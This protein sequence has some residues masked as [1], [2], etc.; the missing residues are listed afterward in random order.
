MKIP[1]SITMLKHHHCLLSISTFSGFQLC[2]GQSVDIEILN[3]VREKMDE[4][5]A[6]V[7]TWSLEQQQ[8]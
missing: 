3:L 2:F 7:Q 5:S 1:S 6:A 4:L 8:V